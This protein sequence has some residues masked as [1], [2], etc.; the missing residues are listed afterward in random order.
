MSLQKIRKLIIEF[1][2][3]DGKPNPPVRYKHII[4]YFT[5]HLCHAAN[6]CDI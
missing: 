6:R 4:I 3:E 1:K 2:E 5:I